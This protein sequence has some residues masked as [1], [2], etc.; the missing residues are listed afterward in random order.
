[1]KTIYMDHVGTNPLHP[2][3]LEE[4]LPYF[5]DNF[6]NP[7]SLYEPAVKAKEAIEN[8][9]QSTALLINAKPNEIIFTSSGAESNNFA[10]KGI[11]LASQKKGKHIITSRIE[12]HSI[13]NTARFL[14]KSG[15]A[16]TYLPVDK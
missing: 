14:E 1:M 16:V 9:R 7:L 5:K 10:V 13:T 3:V 2:E 6:A 4:M 15:F 12:H 11:A 8:A